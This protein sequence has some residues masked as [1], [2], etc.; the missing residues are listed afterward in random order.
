[1]DE[2]AT[3]RAQLQREQKKLALMQD[4]GRALTSGLPLDA[5]LALIMEKVTALMDADRSTLYL[6]SDDRR[7]LWS[8]VQQGGEVVEIRLAVGEGIAG[9]VA[10]SGANVNIVDAYADPRFQ[11]AVDLRSGYRTR[12]ILA[13]P[14]RDSLGTIIGVL[15][16][17][18]KAAGP[19]EA[20]DEELLEAL[21]TQAAIAIENAKLYH[22]VVAQNVELS[23]ARGELEVLFEVERELSAATDL[24]EL[25]ARILAQVTGGGAAAGGAIASCEGDRLRVV[26]THGPS[27]MRQ[28]GRQMPRG[29]GLLGWAVSRREAAIVDDPDADP[30]VVAEIARARAP[31]CRRAACWWRRS[32]TAARCSAPSRSSIGSTSTARAA[33]STTTT[34]SCWCSSPARSPRRSRSPAP[35]TRPPSA[36]AWP[37]SASS[38]PASCTT[39]RRR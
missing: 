21:G 9:A 13:A 16:V 7:E 33:A 39:S 38:S 37:R 19:F 29:E 18:N 3:L 35:A 27:A 1:M 26:T 8:K 2:V 25:L 30:R 36:I 31:S 24:E 11:P 23:R 12:S 17:L 15:Q 6:V 20:S 28:A 5:L 32:S 4:V 10:S 22:S 14:M 34:S